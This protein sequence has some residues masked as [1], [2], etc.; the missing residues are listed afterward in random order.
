MENAA[1]NDDVPLATGTATPAGSDGNWLAGLV[2]ADALALTAIISTGAAL[3]GFP[4][5]DITLSGALL[6]EGLTSEAWQHGPILVATGIALVAGLLALRQAA[7]HG[8]RGWVKA[9]AGAAVLVSA[10]IAIGTVIVWIFA[11]DINPFDVP[12]PG[13]T[14]PPLGN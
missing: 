6:G 8:S 11:P 4:V 9:L 14:P 12:F 7:R 5:L 13:E 2:R 1:G 3:F 10:A